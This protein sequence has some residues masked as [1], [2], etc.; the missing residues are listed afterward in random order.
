MHSPWAAP[1]LGLV[2]V[3]LTVSSVISIRKLKRLRKSRQGQ[4]IGTFALSLPIRKMD[5]WVVR[6]TY[7]EVAAYTG[8]EKEP[9]PLQPSDRL[10]EDLGIDGEDLLDLI[11]AIA[12]RCGRRLDDLD[13]NPLYPKM[14]TVEDLIRVLMEQ[15]KEEGTAGQ[16][17][18][19]PAPRR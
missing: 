2:V 15:P 12:G 7:E 13:R 8:T 6:A 18:S 16:P 10:K 3:A 4:D 17:A 19:A 5:A 1:G 14:K 11:F 9:F